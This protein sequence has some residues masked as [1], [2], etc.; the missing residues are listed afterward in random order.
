MKTDAQKQLSL[1]SF[2]N[3]KK[4]GSTLANLR[5]S[6]VYIRVSTSVGQVFDF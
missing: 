3:M 5:W 4:E 1:Q 6:N 2:A